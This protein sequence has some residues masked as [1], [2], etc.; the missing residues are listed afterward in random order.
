MG[1]QPADVFS[2]VDDGVDAESIARVRIVGFEP[3]N[4]PRL[5]AASHSA[6]R[7]RIVGFQPGAAGN[8]ADA[9][10]TAHADSTDDVDTVDRASM[11]AFEPCA[12]DVAAAASAVRARVLGYAIVTI[13]L[14][15]A[16]APHQSGPAA[17]RR[18]RTGIAAERER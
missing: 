6:V 8:V 2:I 7:S 4:A 1:A 10:S 16:A 18:V 3:D 11:V 13:G 15:S 17:G 5:A 9:D 14:L 12:D